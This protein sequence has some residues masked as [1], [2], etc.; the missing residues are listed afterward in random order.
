VLRQL[1]KREAPS[2]S[3]NDTDFA[4]VLLSERARLIRYCA[5]LTGSQDSAEDL[6][7]ETLLEAWRN[8]HKLDDQVDADGWTKWLSAI[9]RN[10]CMRWWRS[11]GRD[12]AHLTAFHIVADNEEMSVLADLP[13]QD[14]DIEIELERAEL[15]ELL[16]RAL[17][18]LPEET[19]DALIARFIHDSPY[20]E[21]AQRLRISE[22]ALMQ[23]IHRG[24]L[25]LRR[26]ITTHMREEAAAYGLFVP[27]DEKLPR[28][29]R[30]WC[31][32]CG[33]ARLMQYYDTWMQR[34]FT[35]FTCPACW[36]I[37]TYENPQLWAGIHSPKSILA[38]QIAALGEHY[39]R[40]INTFQGTCDLC[41][42]PLHI[43]FC[44]SE[45][46]PPHWRLAGDESYRGIHTTCTRCGDEDYNPV[47]HLMLDTL[48]AQRFWRKHPRI[49]WR[50]GQ[51]IEYQNQPALVG[52]FQDVNEQAQLTIICHR[53]TLKV[54][55]THE[56]M[57]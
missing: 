29:T 12:L 49:Y 1:E 54:L 43:Q 28:E 26:L 57:R 53:E 31:P 41:G 9:A 23:R 3:M 5:R 35:G 17:A 18:L 47:S 51:E 10:V 37:A 36:H 33:R 45:D 24:K 16:D 21:I 11:H 40:T 20:A 25:A 6:A 27:D 34:T 22:E 14:G 32:M 52:S 46:F 50:P 48:E 39:W 19:R 44:N 30:I 8:Q 2:F 7:Q 13:A 38:R 15:A 56:S 4:T 42:G 55:G